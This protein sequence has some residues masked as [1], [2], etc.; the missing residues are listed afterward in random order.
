MFARIVGFSLSNRLLVIALALV[1]ATLG[2]FAAARLPVD[3]FPDL[4]RTNVT[5]MT[6]ATGLAP[7]ETET[8]VTNPVETT[9]AGM[10]GVIRTRSTT[11]SGLSIVTVEFDFGSDVYRNRQLVGERLASVQ[12]LLPA[13]VVPQLA[14]V[15]SIMGEIMLVAVTG[16]GPAASPMAL[17]EIAEF[18]LRPRLLAVPGVAQIIP[19]GGELRQYRVAPRPADLRR[20]GVTLAEVE[21]AARA[22]ATN[23]GGGFVDVAGREYSVRNIG[24]DL[25]IGRLAQLTV[26][27]R[28]GVAVRLDQVA[29]VGFAPGPR[30]G[31]GGSMGRPAVIVSISK[32]P[33]ADTL[34]VTAG[35]EAALQ[36]L[37]RTMPPGVKVDTVTFRQADFI[38]T[39]IANVER[40]LLEALVV[41][42]LVLFAFLMN[43]RTT[44][45]SIIAIPLSVLATALVFQVFGLGINTM[46]LGGIA[47]AVGELVDDA[48]VDVE[49]IARRLRENR[50]LAAPR[51]V[52]EVITAASQEVRSGIIYATAII[53]L[54]FVPLFALSGLEGQLFRPLGIAYVTAILASLVVSITVTPVL[55]SW[56]LPRLRADADHESRL[57]GWLKRRYAAALGWAFRRERLVYGLAVIAVVA[58]VIAAFQL[59]RAFLPPFNE[60]TLTVN[61]TFEPGIALADSARM[62][63]IAERLLLK[64]PE[65]TQV[66]R[67]TGRAELD[68]HAEGVHY[69]EIDVD[70]RP[71][72]R[73]RGAILSDVRSVLAPIPA[74]LNVGQP[75]S[76]R[77]D[78]LVSG[79]RAEIAIKIQ[80][81]DLDTLRSIAGQLEPRLR[82]LPGLVDVQTER[83]VRVPELD[84]R[85]DANAAAAWG[86]TP[87]Q[88]TEMLATLGAG[89]RVAE[90][91]DGPRR[92]DVVV[93]LADGGRTPEALAATIIDTPRGPVPLSALATIVE[94][95]GPNQLLHENGR[96]RLAVLANTNGDASLQ[97]IV[98]EIEAIT[99]KTPLP[100]GYSIRLEGSFEAQREAA[101]TIGLLSLV[102]LALIFAVLFSRYRSA[103]LALIIMGA[104]PLA[105]VGS[106]LA[107]L[108]AGQTLSVASMV[109][110]VTLAGIAARNGILKISHYLNLVLHEG[111]A[112]DE[113]MIVRGSLDRLAPVLMTAL[114]AAIALVP[115]LFD[116]GAPG[117]E[118]L[119][120]VAITIFG[121]LVSSTLLDALVTPLLFRRFGR[122]VALRLAVDTPGGGP[123]AN[124]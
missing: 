101:R 106:V 34:K 93:R 3:V 19:L 9:L 99:A 75:I 41:V 104:I 21:T 84:I 28:D 32:Q 42:A 23:S 120:P 89:T 90:V 66:G 60:G 55:A 71:S 109:G 11:A 59:P 15:S 117:K 114:A 102:S 92:F 111:A 26:A 73:S 16:T 45:I 7:E 91:V 24:R 50:L 112:F 27:V 58:A 25:D 119:H 98:T 74:A 82:A 72:R 110:F 122:A 22:F 116:G 29:D 33:G 37:Q 65:V 68:E 76:H 79:V 69:T 78:H 115:L 88:V 31:D 100:L 118:I 6:E 10:P 2:L 94:S 95:D 43:V 38:T 46:T 48:V 14:P 62:G 36:A 52:H 83:Q 108:I 77:L 63:A 1:V 13:G 20:I 35:V 61:L 70:L 56:L 4:N 8:F 5:V 86:V 124:F 123:V 39:S 67:R 80:G 105:L 47:I 121:G 54:V 12:S 87:A 40:V 57:L 51:R 107:L 44:A 64:I 81:D 96:R 49:N 85:V 17:R 53:V 97:D 103:V 113:A 18:A 30:R